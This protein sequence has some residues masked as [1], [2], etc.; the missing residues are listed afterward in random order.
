MI[1]ESGISLDRLEPEAVDSSLGAVTGAGVIFGVTG[2]VTEAILRAL[3]DDRSMA[4]LNR[5]ASA[6]ERR[7]EG[8]KEFSVDCR[9]PQVSLAVL[10]GLAYARQLIEAIKS[11][12]KR[13]DLIE[14]MT[15][16]GVC[17]AGAGQPSA[18]LSTKEARGRG[19]YA[20]DKM[21]AIKRSGENPLI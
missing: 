12:Q 7:M 1:K 20:E 13:F 6:C 4:G 5:L 10:S 3:S 11:G 8:L 15:C 9:G 18:N 17:V 16:P 19:L 2:G 21:S 14:V